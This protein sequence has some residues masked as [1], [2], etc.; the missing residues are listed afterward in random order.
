MIDDRFNFAGVKHP[1]LTTGDQIVDG[2]RRGNFM[3]EYGVQA[4]DIH[5]TGRVVDVVRVKNFFRDG[6]SHG[7]PFNLGPYQVLSD[8]MLQ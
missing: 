7:T 4:Q 8:N 5:V 6:F 1:V 3:T 2:H